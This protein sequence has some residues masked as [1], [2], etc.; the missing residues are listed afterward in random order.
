MQSSFQQNQQTCGGELPRI[1]LEVGLLQWL[2]DLLRKKNGFIVYALRSFY[3]ILS[4]G[5]KFGHSV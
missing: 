5:P 4:I 2:V 3:G 1:A